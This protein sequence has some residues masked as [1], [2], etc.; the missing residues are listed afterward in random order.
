M[1]Y[2]VEIPIV[3]SMVI[4]IKAGSEDEAIEVAK[5]KFCD[6]LNAYDLENNDEI[7]E[8]SLSS[9][10]Q[11]TDGNVVNYTINEITIIEDLG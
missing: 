11:I 4:V 9:V 3:G 7:I 6:N 2:T 5:A 10:G 8:Y 1:K